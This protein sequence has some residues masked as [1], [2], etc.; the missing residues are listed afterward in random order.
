MPWRRRQ[1]TARQQLQLC[2]FCG[3]VETSMNICLWLVCPCP[4]VIV[5]SENNP[6]WRYPANVSLAF[7]L[8]W[9]RGC[10][11]ITLRSGIW[12]GSSW[13][14]ARS[15]LNGESG[16]RWQYL[17][18]Y[19]NYS[20]FYHT[21]AQHCYFWALAVFLSRTFTMFSSLASQLWETCDFC[22]I[23]FWLWSLKT[24]WF[25]CVVIFLMTAV[26]WQMLCSAVKRMTQLHL[27]LVPKCVYCIVIS[28]RIWWHS[29]LM[30]STLCP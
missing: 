12:M 24:V 5:S 9:C 1:I 22:V 2:S 23:D 6:L 13:Q 27:L 14:R 21:Y 18:I 28:V 19:R 3:W 17:V 7:Q 29:W 10:G 26:L 4:V 8:V 11:R 16:W 15:M 25:N 20:V 30:F